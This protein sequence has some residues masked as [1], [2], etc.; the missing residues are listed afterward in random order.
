[1]LESELQ[2]L[3]DQL[4]EEARVRQ[5]KEEGMKA[6]EAAA[7]DRDAELDERQGRLGALE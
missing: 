3:R 4:A 6:C 1:M 5:E 2:G 7:K